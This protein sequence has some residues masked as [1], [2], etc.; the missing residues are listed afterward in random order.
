MRSLQEHLNQQTQLR[1]HFYGGQTVF[2]PGEQK[3]RLGSF[4]KSDLQYASANLSYLL[5]WIP[6]EDH[7]KIISDILYN[8]DLADMDLDCFELLNKVEI[9]DPQ[10][11][12]QTAA[13]SPVI[14]CTFH[15]GSY[16][17]INPLLV[18]RGFRYILPVDQAI[19][20]EQ[21]QRY[22]DVFDEVREHYKGSPD[23][24]VINARESTS[25]LRM[26]R[27]SKAGW[28]ILT[29]IDGATGVHGES[30]DDDKSLLIHLLDKP[31]YV[32]KGIAFLSYLLKLPIVPVICEYAG[33]T[34]RNL[35]L[36]EA[37]YPDRNTMD[38]DTYFLT[39]TEKI[40]AVL[41]D[42]LK[43]SP[44]QWLGWLDM[45][46]YIDFNAMDDTG[47][48]PTHDESKD[49]DFVFTDIFTLSFNDNR[50]GFVEHDDKRVLLDKQY[51]RVLELPNPIS[52]LIMTC[53]APVEISLKEIDENDKEAILQLIRQGILIAGNRTTA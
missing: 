45:Q 33:L 11:I 25:A 36:H 14:F 1:N 12:L 47:L 9:K 34:E 46:K 40:Y 5:P 10:S 4:L 29:Y 52:D 17:L 42:Y 28:S 50:Y 19:Y 49:M 38:R 8:R 22:M 2:H 6:L 13:D 37:I 41:G 15:F 32:R 20:T 24:M 31:I 23:F 16:R 3:K 26:L 44:A 39:A 30:R 21:K 53:Q 7:T 51:Y 27:K 48:V 43:K 18:S 35:I